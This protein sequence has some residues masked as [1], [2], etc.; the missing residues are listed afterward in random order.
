MQDSVYLE[1]QQLHHG[2]RKTNYS[3]L[4][5]TSKIESAISIAIK[6][7]TI[8]WFVPCNSAASVSLANNVLRATIIC[9]AKLSHQARTAITVEYVIY[10]GGIIRRK[11]YT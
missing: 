3:N 4:E 10:T 11:Y 6:T 9:C 1:P 5:M 8:A 2:S 7:S